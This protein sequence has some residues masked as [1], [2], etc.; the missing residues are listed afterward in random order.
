MSD[1]LPKTNILPLSKF[2]LLVS[3]TFVLLK[4]F[5]F[6]GSA[7]RLQHGIDNPLFLVLGTNLMKN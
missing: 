7:W 4:W 1:M 6:C 5:W 2:H 3:V